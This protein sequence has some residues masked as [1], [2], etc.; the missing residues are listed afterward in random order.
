MTTSNAFF[1]WRGRLGG[2]GGVRY[3]ASMGEAGW[4]KRG[5]CVGVVVDH[6]ITH[7]S[8]W[9]VVFVT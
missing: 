7:R 6:L 5:V 3:W 8:M 2:G 4:G 9:V 1:F